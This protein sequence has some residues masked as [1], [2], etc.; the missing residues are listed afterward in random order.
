MQTITPF[1]WFDGKAEKAMN[2]YVSIVKNSKL[3][4]ACPASSILSRSGVLIVAH[5][6]L[7]DSNSRDRNSWC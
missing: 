5:H 4:S 2:F 1:L 7:I 6:A 3:L